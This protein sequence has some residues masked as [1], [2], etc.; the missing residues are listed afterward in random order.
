MPWR[1]C[2]WSRTCG[3]GGAPRGSF[4]ARDWAARHCQCL[5]QKSRLV[6]R[7]R[8]IQAIKRYRVLNPGIGL[9]EAKDVVDGLVGRVLSSDDEAD[10]EG[11]P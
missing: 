1:G 6:E 5:R 9:K 3:C 2:S 10:P 7:G 4:R 8:K 11:M